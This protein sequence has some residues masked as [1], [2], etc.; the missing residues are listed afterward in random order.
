MYTKELVRTDKYCIILK[1]K[2]DGISDDT[3]IEARTGKT[4]YLWI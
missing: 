2:V 3:V 1:G 4:D